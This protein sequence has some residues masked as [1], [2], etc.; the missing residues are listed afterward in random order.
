MKLKVDHSRCQGH[1]QCY[2]ADPDL[3]PLDDDGYSSVEPHT[4]RP[5]DEERIRQGVDACPMGVFTVDEG[6]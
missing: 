2:A 1:A 6:E 4:V 5:A 3:Y